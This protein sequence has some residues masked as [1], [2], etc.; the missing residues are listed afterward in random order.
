MRARFSGLLPGI[1]LED[2]NR[3]AGFTIAEGIALFPLPR[4]RLRPRAQPAATRILNGRALPQSFSNQIPYVN[5][6]DLTPLPSPRV[7]G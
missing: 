2:E 6:T 1:V 3:L 5:N 4:S 7:L